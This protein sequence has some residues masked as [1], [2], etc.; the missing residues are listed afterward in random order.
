MPYHRDDDT[1]QCE[2]IGGSSFVDDGSAAGCRYHTPEGHAQPMRGERLFLRTLLRPRT[3]MLWC[4][5]WGVPSGLVPILFFPASSFIPAMFMVL[6]IQV[7]V[8]YATLRTFRYVRLATC[9]SDGLWILLQTE[10]GRATITDA[11]QLYVL[12]Q[13]FENGAYEASPYTFRLWKRHLED[14]RVL[15]EVQE[16]LIDAWV[17]SGEPYGPQRTRFFP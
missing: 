2:S 10:E 3:L 16:R 5:A 4:Y 15:A 9:G 13:P 14:E 1:S 7:L 8:V 12:R 6:G 17:N 11:H